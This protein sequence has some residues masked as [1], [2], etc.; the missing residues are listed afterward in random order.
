MGLMVLL[1]AV[2]QISVTAVA[3]KDITFFNAKALP[4]ITESIII[5]GYSAG[6]DRTTSF[7]YGRVIDTGTGAALPSGVTCAN[8]GGNARKMTIQAGSDLPGVYYCDHSGFRLQTVLV[9]SQGYYIRVE[10]API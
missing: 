1:V 6:S 10:K 8:Q 5:G 7:T 9:A 2:F 3:Y 4:N